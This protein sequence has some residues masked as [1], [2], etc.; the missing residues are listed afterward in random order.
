M[1]DAALV[2][3]HWAPFVSTDTERG[4][5]A[6]HEFLCGPCEP[7][8]GGEKQAR[9]IGCRVGPARQGGYARGGREFGPRGG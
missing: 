6:W 1:Q 5:S 4:K 2:S 8:K 3:A 7:V 9:E